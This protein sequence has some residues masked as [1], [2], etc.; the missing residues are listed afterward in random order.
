MRKRCEIDMK[1]EKEK[2]GCMYMYYN[3][4]NKSSTKGT[5]IE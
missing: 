2:S 3:I 5:K 4:T 1:L